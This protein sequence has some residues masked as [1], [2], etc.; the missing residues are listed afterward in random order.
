MLENDRMETASKAVTSIPRRNHIEK[1][2]WRIHRYFVD[3]Q[4]R[5]HA[6]TSTSY[7]CPNFHVDSPSKID[8]ISTNFPRGISKSK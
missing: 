5:I 6:E 3:F 8:E 4:S 2:T 7:R 1:S